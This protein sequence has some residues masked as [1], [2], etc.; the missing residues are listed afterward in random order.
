M[1]SLLNYLFL[2]YKTGL[3]V[4]HKDFDKTNNYYKNLEWITHKENVLYSKKNGR[5]KSL[6]KFGEHNHNSK[7]FE[8]QVKEIKKMLKNG[9]SVSEIAK[10]YER[11]WQTINHIKQG[12]TWKNI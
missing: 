12:D 6:N 8:Y 11:G 1:F 2:G 9:Y 3:E 10:K 7:L 5:Y 4:N